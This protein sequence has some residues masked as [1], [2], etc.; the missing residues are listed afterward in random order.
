MENLY[1]GLIENNSDICICDF[2]KNDVIANN[3]APLLMTNKRQI[4]DS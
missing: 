2:F 1:N 3:W 4:F